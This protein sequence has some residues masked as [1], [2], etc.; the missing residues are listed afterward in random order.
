MKIRL[1][2]LLLLGCPLAS[3][4]EET[5]KGP[6][7]TKIVPPTS[8]GE[9]PRAVVIPADVAPT[10]DLAVEAAIPPSVKALGEPAMLPFPDG[11]QMAV[12]ASSEKAQAHVNQG[13]NHVHGGWEF[14][15]SRHFAAAM[16]ADPECLL[17]HWGMLLSMLTPSPETDPARVAVTSRLLD[18][19]EKGNGSEL[20]RG[21]AYGLI[22][23]IQEG[24]VAAANAFQKVAAKF[25]NDMQATI[26]AALF[27]RGGYDEFGSATPAQETAEKSLLALTEKF[28]DSPVPLN[29]LLTIRAEAPDLSPWLALTTR[30]TQ[31]SPNYPPYLHVLGH[32]HWRSGQHRQAAA[33]FGSAAALY[34]SWMK[35]NNATIADCPEWGKAECYRIVAL[36]SMG[37]FDTASTAA[38]QLAATPIPKNRPTSPGARLLMWDAK[39]LPAR[40]LLYR[41]LPAEALKTLP[42]PSETQQLRKHSLSHLWIDGLRL[43]LE[44]MRQLD[45]RNLV[46]AREVATVLSQLGDGFSKTQATATASGE[47]SSWNRAFRGLEVLSSDLRG[48]LAAAGPKGTAGTAYNWFASAADRQ[49]P[50]PM[51]FPPMI[52]TPMANRVGRFYLTAGQ[53]TEAIEAFQ[54]ALVAFPNDINALRGLKSAFEAAKLPDR[55]LETEGKIQ[56]LRAE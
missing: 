8:D 33:A 31:I 13:M 26:F 52:L 40:I 36:T 15:A 18:L 41:D 3:G 39:T 53:P 46:A 50:A 29:A 11:I 12:T 56:A 47:R 44:V 9:Q 20:E 14:E 45:A 19:V 24:P 49:H 34:Q 43:S 22:K 54:R 48:Q 1:L 25:P 35:Q 5:P 38:R 17:A 55:A 10:W 4:E 2:A 51:M 6:V 7:K 30:L 32:Y 27:G 21:F 28:P 23:Y 37:D 42:K 16:R